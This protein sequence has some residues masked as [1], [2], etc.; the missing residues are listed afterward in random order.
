MINI[1]YSE[2]LWAS[3]LAQMVESLSAMQETWVRSLGQEDLLEKG[4][5][6]PLQYSCLE[7]SMDR[8]AWRTR[9]P[10]ML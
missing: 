3:L 10:D 8:G 6:Y 4:M 5:A 2:L 7:S 1:D 9:E